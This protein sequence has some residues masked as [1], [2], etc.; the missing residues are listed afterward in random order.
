MGSAPQGKRHDSPAPEPAVLKGKKEEGG[1]ARDMISAGK[2]GVAGGAGLRCPP[3]LPWGEAG[4]TSANFWR[5]ESTRLAS[6]MQFVSH[7][8]A[9][10]VLFDHLFDGPRLKADVT[11]TSYRTIRR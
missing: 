1:Q 11:Y 2:T 6:D 7:S 10:V 5:A 4:N 3:D 9:T 8:L